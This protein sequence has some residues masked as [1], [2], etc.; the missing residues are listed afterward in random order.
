MDKKVFFEALKR[1]DEEAWQLA[2]DRFAPIVKSHLKRAP[3]KEDL[4]DCKDIW[5]ETVLIIIDK[6][7]KDD[8][9]GD[10]NHYIS[11][12]IANLWKKKWSSKKNNSFISLDEI[13]NSLSDDLKTPERLQIIYEITE[14]VFDEM[15]KSP[16]NANCVQ[17]I[18]AQLF[19]KKSDRQLAK[20][21]GMSEA[22]IRVRRNKICMPYFVELFHKHPKFKDLFT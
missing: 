16:K 15:K 2:Y 4:K 10:I 9:I 13:Q 1:G 20:E 5:Q 18:S 3:T 14:S 21:L 19:E 8:D 7:E 12:I 11:G 17:I 22:Y 6:L